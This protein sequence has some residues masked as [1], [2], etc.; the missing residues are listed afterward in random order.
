MIP[1]LR[2]V[3]EIPSWGTLA[4]VV[5]GEHDGVDVLLVPADRILP[6]VARR[7]ERP[8]RNGPVRLARDPDGDPR[9]RRQRDTHA[10]RARSVQSQRQAVELLESLLDETQ[11][12]S[13]RKHRRFLV[14]TGYGDVELGRFGRLAFSRCDGARF[15]LCVVPNVYKDLPDADI[16]TNLL[17][18]VKSS[19]ERF[20]EV[21]NWTAGSGWRRGPVPLV[22]GL[23]L[24]L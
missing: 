12:T 7:Q 9:P 5:G 19:P 8:P 20:F 6:G 17:L 23:Q 10:E 13:W 15:T 16:W 11:L 3:E 24:S 21:A 1:R 14:V 2:F 4:C 22:R 18:A